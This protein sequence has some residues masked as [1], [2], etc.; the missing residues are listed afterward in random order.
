MANNSEKGPSWFIIFL[1]T[2][3]VYIY[4]LRKYVDMPVQYTYI[5]LLYVQYSTLTTQRKVSYPV[6]VLNKG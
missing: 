1:L 6:P 5:L 3:Y 2:M 4:V